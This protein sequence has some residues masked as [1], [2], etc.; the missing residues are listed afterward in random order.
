[1]IT[2]G[3][4]EEEAPKVIT[5]PVLNLGRTEEAYAIIM[6]LKKNLHR[7][8]EIQLK[9][10]EISIL[11]KKHQFAFKGDGTKDN[12]KHLIN[13][14]HFKLAG[15]LFFV[16]IQQEIVH[17]NDL[18]HIITNKDKIK[19]FHWNFQVFYDFLKQMIFESNGT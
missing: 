2:S 19:T 1:M 3:S 17:K 16:E 18:P 11:D 7:F 15:K 8:K 14:R 12:F 4:D 13:K 5:N 6:P 9:I 10:T